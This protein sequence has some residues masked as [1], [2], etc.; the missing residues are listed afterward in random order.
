MSVAIGHYSPVAGRFVVP[1]D[2]AVQVFFAISGFYM[3]LVLNEKY[4]DSYGSFLANRA[5]RLL[6]L[7][8]ITVALSVVLQPLNAQAWEALAT[9]GLPAI[10]DGESL[11]GQARS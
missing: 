8:W 7:Y 9:Q 6:P 2:T 11:P 1:G 3:T 10:C 4:L 5:L